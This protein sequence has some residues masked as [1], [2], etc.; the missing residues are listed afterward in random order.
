[1]RVPE[2]QNMAAN[3]DHEIVDMI[4]GGHDHTYFIELN[5]KTNVH[6]TKSGTD[7]ECFT[8]QTVLFG[9]ELA[10]FLSYQQKIL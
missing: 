5:Q 3:N 6:T 2:D 1:M 8:N 10:D 9:V 4:F 7:F